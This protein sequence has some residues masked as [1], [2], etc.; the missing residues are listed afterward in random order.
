MLTALRWEG[1]IFSCLFRGGGSKPP[2]DP[3]VLQWL[4]SF[5][6]LFIHNEHRKLE[7]VCK[8]SALV[9]I[10]ARHFQQATA[11]FSNKYA[12]NTL[13]HNP[14]GNTT[15]QYKQTLVRRAHVHDNGSLF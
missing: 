7:N 14:F 10:S 15:L 12:F 1:V 4:Y 8:V 11:I 2:G 6:F 9:T 3:S 5:V 13:L